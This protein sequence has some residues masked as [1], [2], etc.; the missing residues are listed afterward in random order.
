MKRGL[1]L[2]MF[3]KLAPHVILSHCVLIRHIVNIQV[4]HV[5]CISYWSWSRKPK[6]PIC[7]KRSH[8]FLLLSFQSFLVS[9]SSHAQLFCPYTILQVLQYP[10]TESSFLLLLISVCCNPETELI[11]LH[12]SG[13]MLLSCSPFIKSFSLCGSQKP[14]QTSLH[15]KR[16]FAVHVIKN[17]VIFPN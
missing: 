5:K 4:H 6:I 7:R 2:A 1:Q 14:T 13:S 8:E 12:V 17:L 11:T 16:Q 10:S 9:C 15:T 3:S